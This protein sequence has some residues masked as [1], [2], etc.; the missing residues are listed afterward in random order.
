MAARRLRFERSNH[1][2]E[3][4]ALVNE[5]YL[6]LVGSEPST[7]PGQ[8]NFLRLCS[9]LMRNV[10]IDYARK[11]NSAK[12]GGSSDQKP[13]SENFC[14]QSKSCSDSRA[15]DAALARL[16][17]LDARKGEVVKLRFFGGL[18]TSEIALALRVSRNTVLS[19]WSRSRAWLRGIL[20]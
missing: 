8:V 11:Q 19:D 13:P 6:R 20:G 4:A 18:T 1:L 15:L 9:R 2:L 16:S 7:C 17:A 5:V 10:L 3:P 14:G 12:E